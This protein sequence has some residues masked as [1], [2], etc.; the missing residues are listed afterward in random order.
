MKE[1]VSDEL[2]S[3]KDIRPGMWILVRYNEERFLK[4]VLQKS[5]GEYMVSR[6]LFSGF[7]VNTLKDLKRMKVFTMLKFTD[8]I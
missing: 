1:A 7:G 8:Q 3:Y 5:C 4:K 2:M 6:C